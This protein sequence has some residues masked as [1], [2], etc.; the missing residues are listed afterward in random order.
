[1]WC[2]RC[3]DTYAH[4]S[5]G[6]DEHPHAAWI[7]LCERCIAELGEDRAAVTLE[8]AEY[9]QRIAGPHGPVTRSRHRYGR[10]D[11]YAG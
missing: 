4:A 9:A 5:L 10:G 11:A 1:M 8:Q 3:P 7:V 2:D 6:T